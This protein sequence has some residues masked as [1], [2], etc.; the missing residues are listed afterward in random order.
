[1]RLKIGLFVFVTILCFVFGLS[2]LQVTPVENKQLLKPPVVGKPHIPIALKDAAPVLLPAGQN[3]SHSFVFL[4]E[5]DKVKIRSIELLDD[6]IVLHEPAGK[7]HFVPA[8]MQAEFPIKL[9]AMQAGRYYLK[10]NVTLDSQ[11]D[12]TPYDGFDKKV[13]AI[14]QVGLPTSELSTKQKMTSA[15]HYDVLPVEEK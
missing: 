6:G 9:L 5:S 2:L 12:D 8:V 7:L 10:F 13:T 11:S 14:I 3:V 4:S 15:E 1:M